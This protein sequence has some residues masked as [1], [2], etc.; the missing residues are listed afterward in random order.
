MT[1][2]PFAIDGPALI[3]FSGGRTSAYMLRRILDEGLRPDVRVAFANTGKE[4]S[5]TLDFVHECETRWGVP[6]AWLE[7][8]GKRVTYET[9]SRDGA[10]YAELIA[11]RKFL[12][13]PVTRFCTTELKIRRIKAFMLAEG[14]EHWTM[15][16]GIRADEPSRVA[17]L[18]A[19]TKERWENALPLAE[20][21]VIE[22]DVLRFW[23][24]QPFDLQL[25]TWEGNC[26]LCFLKGESK[27]RRIMED[28][29]DL[30]SWWIQQESALNVAP[31]RAD[32][33]RYAALLANV[34]AQTRMPWA[35]GMGMD[36]LGDCLC[37][38]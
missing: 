10:P 31:F 34:Q 22:T 5:E 19:P 20:A 8:P 30:V 26:D 37:H 25:R 29:P 32:R 24:S 4:R 11:K 33:P 16:I 21:G 12:P 35:A 27:I 6:I 18:R 23:K 17:K 7:Y 14:F 28:R 9:A 3:S 1:R 15:V 2:S 38:D 13:N 36:D